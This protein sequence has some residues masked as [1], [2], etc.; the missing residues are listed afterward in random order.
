VKVFFFDESRF[1]THSKIGHGWFQKGSRTTVPVKLGF[2]NFYLYSAVDSLS[3]DACT[4]LLPKVN[5]E[6]MNIFL[7]ELGQQYGEHPILLVMDGASWHKSRSLNLPE[8]V[9]IVYLPPYSP[10]LNPV[11]R[12]WH[13]IKANTIRNKTFLSIELLKDAIC[14]FVSSLKHSLLKSLCSCSYLFN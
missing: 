9:E 1:G 10:E 14:S 6:C 2:K 13:Y 3:G 12:L 11:E 7:Q 4:L 5:T 8:N